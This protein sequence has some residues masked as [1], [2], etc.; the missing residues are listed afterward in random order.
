MKNKKVVI[1]LLVL[2]FLVTS[3]CLFATYNI[4][5]GLDEMR[6]VSQ[7]QPMLKKELIKRFEQRQSL[8]LAHF[9]QNMQAF[10][11]FFDFPT[12]TQFDTFEQEIR[13][14]LDRSRQEYEMLD[15]DA[16]KSSTFMI[17]NTDKQF[18][19]TSILQNVTEAMLDVTIDRGF[20]IVT[21]GQ[22]QEEAKDGEK[23][24]AEL[25][26][27]SSFKRVVKLPA[28]VDVSKAK[29]TFKENILTVTM[30]KTEL[31]KQEPLK[32]KIN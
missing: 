10:N 31:A 11:E 28:N 23:N 1:V 8:A 27:F 24:Q 16:I 6:N 17:E 25:K 18:K 21:A 7:Q 19:V 3:V 12:R 5:Q 15:P 14:M 20:L 13:K 2:S 4:Y 30:P 32:L 22:K 26:R 29:V 9:E